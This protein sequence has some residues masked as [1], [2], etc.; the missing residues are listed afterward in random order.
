[1]EGVSVVVEEGVK[2]GLMGEVS[3]LS[4]ADMTMGWRRVGD[5]LL[6]FC[7]SV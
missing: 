5:G 3:V 7:T 1:M 2:E 4:T 6:Y